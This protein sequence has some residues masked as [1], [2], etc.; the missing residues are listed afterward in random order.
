MAQVFSPEQNIDLAGQVELA[1][2]KQGSWKALE[3]GSDFIN[4]ADSFGMGGI[5]YAATSIYVPTARKMR[6]SFGVDY[7]AKVWLNGTL[8]EDLSQ[9]DSPP[10]KGQFVFDADIKAGWNELLL[11]VESGS[12]GNSFWLGISDP[13]DVRVARKPAAGAAT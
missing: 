5:S 1:P 2:G 9:R 4:L 11:K 12:G 8:I 7:W 6:F 10:A 3:G 13:G